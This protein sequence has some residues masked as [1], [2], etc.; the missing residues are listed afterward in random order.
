M[1]AGDHESAQW[2]QNRMNQLMWK[3]YGGK[4]ITCWLAGEKYLLV[5]MGLFQTRTTLLHY[6]L[7]AACRRAID[8]VIKQ[9]R[10]LLMPWESDS[11]KA[12]FERRGDGRSAT[13]PTA[14]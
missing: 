3:V 7:T 8:G 10:V 9:A 12:G 2:M 14:P 13:A 11:G 1:V 5:R 6:P 4:K